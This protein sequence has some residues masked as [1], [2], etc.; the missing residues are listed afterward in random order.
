MDCK[1]ARQRSGKP[2]AAGDGWLGVAGKGVERDNVGVHLKLLK[3][4]KL[5]GNP[6]I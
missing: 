5:T 1:Y 3:L 4:L 2:L 6:K